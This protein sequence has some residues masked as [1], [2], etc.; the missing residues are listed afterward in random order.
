[1]DIAKLKTTWKTWTSV[2]CSGGVPVPVFVEAGREV[3]CIKCSCGL[4]GSSRYWCSYDKRHSS[5]YRTF[6]TS[7]P[8][9]QQR[10]RFFGM[11]TI[12]LSI[13]LTELNHIAS[14]LF[15]R[16]KLYGKTIFETDFWRK[17]NRCLFCFQPNHVP[18]LPRLEL[19]L[20]KK[21]FRI[22]FDS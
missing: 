16:T 17:K 7:P 21:G 15:P 9:L 2:A 11:T 6:E 8:K 12:G 20:N 18:N 14:L 3:G 5:T 4:T 13:T 10:N 19:C 1:M 22:D